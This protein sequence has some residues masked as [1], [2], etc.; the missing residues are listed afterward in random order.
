MSKLLLLIGL[1]MIG[2][3][4]IIAWPLIYASAHY[5]VVR[6]RILEVFSEPLPDDQ[7]RLSIAYEFPVPSRQQRV[8]AIGHAQADRS[9]HR[10]ESVVIPA[11]RLASIEHTLIHVTPS[12]RVFYDVNDPIGSAFMLTDLS[13]VEGIGHDQGLVLII[14]GLLLWCIAFLVRHKR[15]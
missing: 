13:A 14:G 5:Q 4:G 7:V 2:Y 9:M 12:R 3:G 15:I 6:G 8:V 10:V 1:G 11:T